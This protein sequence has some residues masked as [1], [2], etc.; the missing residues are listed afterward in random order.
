M[1]WINS[2]L[3]PAIVSVLAV[4]SSYYATYRINNISQKE[5]KR[6]KTIDFVDYLLIDLNKLIQVL[7]KLKDDAE[8]YN[9]FL[10]TNIEIAKNIINKLKSQ[11]DKVIL[12]EDDSLRRGIIEL[13]DNA[14]T[15]ALE[16]ETME[17]YPVNEFNKLEYTRS[18]RLKELRG[19]R[20]Q[21]LELGY[22][23][24]VN[25]NSKTHRIDGKKVKKDLALETVDKILLDLVSDLSNSEQNLNKIKAENEKKRS[26]LIIRILDTQTKLR[27]LNTTL[28][29][30]KAD[31]AKQ[32]RFLIPFIRR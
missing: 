5:D 23:I 21:L 15:I 17:Q 13:I 26:F 25:D 18:E 8:K 9:F 6:L 7:E 1:D 10:L 22:Y 24:D 12:F 27:E 2:L 3:F 31:L 28:T 4:I 16:M 11:T 14:G 29:D 32:K 30:K 19:I 20:L